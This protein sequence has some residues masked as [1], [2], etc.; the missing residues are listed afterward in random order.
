MFWKKRDRQWNPYLAGALTG[1][2]AVASAFATT[3]VVGKTMILS[4]SK[5]YVGAAAV[6]EKRLLPAHTAKKKD[7]KNSKVVWDWSTALLVGIFMGALAAALSGRAFEWE[8]V[9]DRWRKRFGT[10]ILK[11]ALGGF[12]GG[13]C[14][15]FGVRLA[16]GGVSGLILS[17]TMQL[18]VAGLVGMFCFFLGGAATAKYLN[19][20]GGSYD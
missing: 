19:S 8:G 7:V 17:G 20:K 2:L 15:L 10:S 9:P 6:L 11:R 13:A 4:S 3:R 12:V 1:L 14:V 16:G 18:S 5:P